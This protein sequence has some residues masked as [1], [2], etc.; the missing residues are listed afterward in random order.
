MVFED[1]GATLP[2][3]TISRHL[4]NM[5]YT[6]KYVRKGIANL[7]YVVNDKCL[8]QAEEEGVCG[9][10][11]RHHDEG[12]MIVY[13]DETNYNQ[14][15]KRTRGR[16]KNGKR[17]VEKLPP[18]KG[19]KLQIQCALSSSFGELYKM[20]KESD[21]YN[22]EYANIKVIVVFGNA[23]AHSR[24]ETLVPDCDDLILLR[25]GLYSPMCNPIENCFSSMKAIIK[26]YL[27]LMRD[28]MNGPL[29]ISKGQPISKTETR[30]RP[31]ERAAHVSMVEITQRMLHRMELHVSQFVNA[32]VRTE[33]MEYGA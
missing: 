12:N 18:S 22:E 24:I 13:F 1:F 10:C 6:A 17:E 3:T 15:T 29:L 16:A 30:M 14:N 11:I 26:Q 20:M 23:P 27:A 33:G 32:A 21:V 28:E 9:N 8:T 19:A 31:L 7:C 4:V 2:E 5:L 25:L